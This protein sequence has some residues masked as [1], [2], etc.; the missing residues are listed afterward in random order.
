MATI[1]SVGEDE[2]GLRLRDK[3]R[4]AEWPDRR[5]VFTL[6]AGVSLLLFYVLAMQCIS[7]LAIIRRE[8]QSWKWPIIQFTYMT[9]LAYFVSLIAYQLLK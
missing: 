7:T 9:T 3:L 8:T 5:P 2:E 1:Y 6:A 4:M